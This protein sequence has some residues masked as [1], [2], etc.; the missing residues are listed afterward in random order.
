MEPE[1]R[2]RPLDHELL[3]RAQHPLPRVL[4]ID[5]VNDELRDH[6]VV[7][8]GDLVS[9]PHPGIHAHSD[10]RRLPV[11]RDPPGRGKKRARDVLRVDA[12]LEGMPA[13]LDLLLRDRK[14]LPCRDLDLL[15]NDVDARHDLGDGVLDLHA[16]VHLEEVVRAVGVEEPFDRPCG[17]VADGASRIDRDPADPCPKLGIHSRRRSLLDQ[18]LVTSL[19][20]AVALAEMDHVAMRVRQDL[21]LDV[22]RVVEVALDVDGVRR[23]STPRPRDAQSRTPARPR[24]LRARRAGPFLHLRP[25]L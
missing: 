22:P 4:A 5:V 15:A 16:R 11:G 2:G 14:W 9:R 13:K 6:R 24:L 17:A 1:E 8:L 12:A 19:D 10:A 21:N 25:T 7:E 3:E 20:G 23:R 18:L